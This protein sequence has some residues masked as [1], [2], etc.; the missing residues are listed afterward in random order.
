LR[1]RV[2][3]LKNVTFQKDLGSYYDK[4][5][6][7]QKLAS[8]I[9]Q[10]LEDAGVKV[11]A[12]IVHKAAL[13]AKTDLTTELVKEFTELQGIVGG[14]YAKA[15]GLDPAIG[16][17]IYDQY[18]PESM[19]D[20]VPRTLEGAVLSIADKADSIIGMFYL[21]LHPS[22][23]KDPFAL[24]RQ[25]NGILRIIAG[26]KLPITFSD[27][28][29][30]AVLGY[31]GT[32]LEARFAGHLVGGEGDLA[33]FF[34]ERVEFYL[35]DVRGFAYDTV[36]AVIAAGSDDVV[37]AVARAEALTKIRGNP[38]FEAIT[39]AFIRIKGILGQ[40]REKRFHVRSA[41]QY[42][43]N[44]PDEQKQLAVN[45]ESTKNL[46]ERFRAERD[47]LGALIQ[48]SA[49]RPRV[50]EFF[51]RVMVMV[52]EDEIRSNRLA[53]FQKLMDDFSS[54]ADFSEIVTEKK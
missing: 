28:E 24:R 18:K 15:Q 19:E 54:I 50:D 52:P 7:V 21:G 23:S 22:G 20:A 14:L 48:L 43:H 1:E 41:F 45:A 29:R 6:R 32:P 10:T 8:Q 42:E 26:H 46:F 53:L 25:A 35:R 16:D 5:M 37:D 13:L 39:A 2:E 33:R 12:G 38:D 3:R 9:S 51:D 40:A 17:A 34:R 4:S 44:D 36:R 31:N 27:L 30:S 11:R 49:L 47:Y